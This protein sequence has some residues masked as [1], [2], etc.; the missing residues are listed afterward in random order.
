MRRFLEL[1]TNYFFVWTI[2]AGVVALLYPQA[3]LWFRGAWIPASLGVIMLGMGITLTVDD[4]RRIAEQPRRALTGVALQYLVM[5]LL[6]WGLGLAFGLGTA[7]AVGLILVACCPGGTASN[8]ISF[9][10]KADVGLSVSMTALSTLASV[11]LTPALT[12]ILVGGRMEVDSFGLVQTTLV[13]VVGP[14][15]LGLILNRYLHGFSRSIQPFAPP[16]AVI[17]IILIVGSILA[18][19]GSRV[20]AGPGRGL[21]LIGAVFLLHAFGFAFGYGLSLLLTGDETS[22]RT[23]SIEVGMQNSGLGVELARRNFS[24]PITALPAALSALCHCLVGSMLAAWWRRTADT[25]SE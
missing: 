4:F 16:L 14:V 6:G 22:A 10:A 19:S 12:S 5:P 20:L 18:G 1:V 23:V 13:V 24:D 7:E 2:A 8:V 9:L 15:S 25:K 11:I 21:P 17:L 3:F